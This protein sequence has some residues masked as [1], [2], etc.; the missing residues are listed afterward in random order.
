MTVAQIN[1]KAR[2]DLAEYQANRADTKGIFGFVGD[3]FKPVLDFGVSKVFPG[4]KAFMGTL[5]GDEK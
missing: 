3:L 4:S 5:A 1:A 2:S